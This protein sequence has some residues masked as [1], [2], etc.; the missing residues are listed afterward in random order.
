MVYVVQPTTRILFSIVLEDTAVQDFLGA[1]KEHHTDTALHSERVGVYTLD[2]YV[3]GYMTTRSGLVVINQENISEALRWGTAGVCHDAGKLLTPVEILAKPGKLDE[4][5][6]ARMNK[7]PL[8]GLQILDEYTRDEAVYHAAVGHHEYKT[9]ASYPRHKRRGEDD[10][11]EAVALAD[12][13]DALA[14]KRGYKPAFSRE[15][16]GRIMHEEFNGN[17]Q[18]LDELLRRAS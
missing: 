2:M 9:R 16:I 12:F 8:L 10:L 5:E 11:V 7:H 4:K 1:M 14:S 13:Y 6:R 18:H 15:E 3:T 17:P